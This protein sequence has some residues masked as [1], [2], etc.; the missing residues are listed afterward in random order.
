VE[1]VLHFAYIGEYSKNLFKIQFARKAEIY[2]K[3]FTH[4]IEANFLKIVAPGGRKGP[5]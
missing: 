3:T 2:L 5:Q 4:S 1:T